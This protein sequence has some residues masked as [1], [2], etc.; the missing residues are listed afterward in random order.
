MPPKKSKN[1][2]SR[3][4]VMSDESDIEDESSVA[5]LLR[6]LTKSV[7]RV[8]TKLDTVIVDVK[9]LKEKQIE[10]E[11]AITKISGEHESMK[12]DVKRLKDALHDKEA[13]LRGNSVRVHGLPLDA[14]RESDPLYVITAVYERVV[15]PV[16]DVALAQ[17]MIT[18]VPKIYDLFEYGHILPSRQATLK[19]KTIIVR[20]FSRI[21]RTA[22]LKLKKIHTPPLSGD[23][24]KKAGGALRITVT[25]DLTS[26]TFKKLRE[27]QDRVDIDRAWTINGKIRYI[28]TNETTVKVLKSV[29]DDE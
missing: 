17:G 4:Q 3:G 27:M 22:F 9:S 14:T 18:F 12:K 13:Y 19:P 24:L 11:A 28:H 15:K 10:Q 1:N 2:K 23:E 16:L 8:E 21:F 7:S 25:E 26:E 5:E 6:E 20:F 29:F